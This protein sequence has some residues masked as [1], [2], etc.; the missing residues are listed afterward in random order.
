MKH[1][2]NITAIMVFL[3]VGF[4]VF[5]GSAYAVT[6]KTLTVGS[7]S[8]SYGDTVAVPITIDDPAGVGGVA[9]ALSYNPA[10]FEFQGLEEV[11]P[12]PISDG[13]DFKVPEDQVRSIDGIEYLYYNPYKKEA[14]YSDITYDFIVPDTGPYTWDNLPAP[15]LFF[16]TNVVTDQLLGNQVGKV[17]VAAASATS[18]Q[19]NTIFK[20][21]FLIRDGVQ[22]GTYPIGLNRTII[23][24]PAAGYDKATFIPALVG[25]PAA[26]PTNNYYP[27]PVFTT[28]LNRGSICVTPPATSLF[29]ISGNVTYEGG[30]PAA[31]GTPVRLEKL[32]DSVYVYKAK[33]T[34]SSG[35]YSFADNLAGTYRVCVRSLDPNF[36]NKCEDCEITNADVTEH[37]VLPA[38]VRV[39]GNVTINDGYISGLKV[40]VMNGVQVMGIYPVNPDGSYQSGP[41][42]PGVTY[43]AY[44][45]YGSL[46]SNELTLGGT[47]SWV[48]DLYT[49]SGTVSGLPADAI[50]TITAGSSNGQLMKTIASDPAGVDGNATYSVSDLVPASDYIVS[51]GAEGFAVLYYDGKDAFSEADPVDISI[52]NVTDINLTFPDDKATI[53]GTITEDGTAVVG[54]GVFA[55]NVNTFALV[56]VVTDGSG[57]YELTLSPGS[58]ELFVIKDSG[59]VFY[60]DADSEGHVTQNE[61][62]ADILEVTTTTPLI[63]KDMDVIEC[64]ETITGKVT[65]ERSD[66]SPVAFALITATSG[67]K[68]AGT[69]T[70]ID[71]RY[72][73]SG[74]CDGLV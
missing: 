27:T 44:A 56:S 28:T 6:D 9:F 54:I 71:G 53:A 42:R 33:T 36:Y 46:T 57:V 70:G 61:A 32:T 64:D 73:L 74:L 5:S 47:D 14:P 66:G 43:T 21:K 7:G 68:R 41:L 2:K 55:F 39:S 49:I 38:P 1:I 40:K 35:S 10:V 26:E 4:F 29:T 22:K 51:A 24:N 12:P 8:G 20:A 15:A 37:V 45:V 18:L 59:A 63:D 50:A 58:Y 52:G 11:S 13:S 23:L 65:Y 19:A 62:K 25:M 17:M 3:L 48:T 60:Y 69:I 31:N 30:S 67:D 16:Q 72:T 34:V